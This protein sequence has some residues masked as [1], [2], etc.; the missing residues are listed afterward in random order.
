MQLRGATHT[1]T[2]VSMGHQNAIVIPVYRIYMYPIISTHERLEFVGRF[3][4]DAMERRKRQQE[5][6]VAVGR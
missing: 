5:V 6:F 4:S 1:V 2:L 3:W